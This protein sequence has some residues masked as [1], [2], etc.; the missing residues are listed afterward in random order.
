M[1]S[2]AGCSSHS[3][4]ANINVNINQNSEIYVENEDFQYYLDSFSTFA[5][6][7]GGYYFVDG[8]NLFFF[9]CQTKQ[10]YPVC[11]KVN[12]D[13]SNSN[14]MSYLSP[15]RFF[16]GTSIGYYNDSIYNLGYESDNSALKHNYMYQISLEDFKQRKGAYLYD[17]IGLSIAYIMHRGYVYYTNDGG[18]MKETTATIYRAMLGN[19]G[20]N[21]SEKVFEY[22]AIGASIIGLKAYGNYIFF[23]TASYEDTQGNGY[24]TVLNCL[25]IHTLEAQQLTGDIYSYVAEGGKVYYEPDEKTVICL[26]LETG[27]ETLFCN[28]EGPCYISADSKYLY[29]DNIQ[30]TGINENVKE[31]K[32]YVYDK[33]GNYI[34]EIIPKNSKDDCYFGGDDIM[35]FRDISAGENS[36]SHGYYMLDKAT[37]PDSYEFTYMNAE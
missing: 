25:N 28:I 33:S 12:C 6:A 34:T 36:D 26:D 21:A 11:N 22:S 31:R 37:L 19:T 35:I 16:V 18:E 32:I 29:F 13:H 10:M 20:Q 9:D 8:L 2:Y 1:L 30:A 17:S 23:K 15:F 24:K 7:N 4:T 14:C 27:E 3:S 5:K